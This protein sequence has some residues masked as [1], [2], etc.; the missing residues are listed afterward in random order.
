MSV[1]PE[2][3]VVPVYGA[4]DVYAVPVVSWFFIS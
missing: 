2:V 3:S 1:V 4:C